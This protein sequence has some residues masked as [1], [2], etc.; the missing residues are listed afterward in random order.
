M[1]I[2]PPRALH[3][4]DSNC[5]NRLTP[6][7]LAGTLI[8]DNTSLTFADLDG[9]VFTFTENSANATFAGAD[10]KNFGCAA[11]ERGRVTGINIPYI[12]NRLNGNFTSSAEGIFNLA[13][14]ITQ[15]AARA[16]RLALKSWKLSLSTSP[17]IWPNRLRTEECRS[18]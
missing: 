7:G 16:L 3:A 9:Q 1:A 14:D 17:A 10:S 11:S 6:I 8:A 13:Y 5:F 15:R 12:A 4:D 18:H 2:T